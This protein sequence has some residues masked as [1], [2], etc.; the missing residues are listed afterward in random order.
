MG[1]FLD[2]RSQMARMNIRLFRVGLSCSFLVLASGITVA[3]EPAAKAP[4]VPIARAVVREVTDH[5]DFTG[6]TEAPI[7]VD[8]RARA[9]GYLIKAA[10]REGAEVKQGDVLFEIDPR[11]YQAEL[12]KVEA[13]VKLAEAHLKLA[14]AVQMRAAAQLAQKTIG[15]EEFDRVAGERILAEAQVGAA[16]ARRTLA[17]L[18][19]DYTRVLAPVGGRV[20]RRLVD[21]GNLVKADET[22]LA[23]L[24]SRSTV[25]IY[26]DVDERS[27]LRLLRLVRE[28]KAKTEKIPAAIGLADEEGFPHRGVVDLTDNQ[29]NPDTG[30]LRMR[31]VLANKDGLLMPGMFVRVRLTIGEPHKVVCIPEQAVMVEEGLRYVFVVGDKDAIERQAV[32]LGPQRNGQRVVTR[33]LKVDERIVVGRLQGL[34]PGMVVRPR[35]Q[36][37]PAPKQE[38]YPES[39]GASAAPSMWGQAGSGILVGTVYPGASAQVVSDAV[40]VP[41]EQQVN[42]LETIRSLR[43]RCTHDGKYSLAL[44]FARG[45]D[46]K[47]MQVLVQNRVNLALPVLPRVLQNTGV[48]VKQGTSGVLMIVNLSSPGDNHDDL[49]LGNY[50]NIQI[51]DELARLPGVGEVAL[52]GQ[53]D[54]GLRVCLDPDKL[55]ARSLNAGDVVRALKDQNIKVMAGEIGPPPV[56]RGRVF[57]YRLSTMGRLIN[58]EGFADIILRADG[59]GRIIRLKDVAHIELSTGGPQSQAFFNGRPVAALVIRSTGEAPLRKVQIALQDVLSQLRARLAKGLDLAVAFDFTANLEIPERPATPE[60]LLL[61]LHLPASASAERALQVLKHCQTL[62]RPLP[63]VQDVLAMSDNPFDLF[64][65]GPCILV[66]LTPAEKR[67]AGREEVARAIRAKLDEFKELTLRLRDLSGPGR[68]PRCGYPIDLAIRGPELERVREFAKKLVE[69]M[70]ESK[71]LTDVWANPDSE[72]RLQR[73]VEIDRTAAAARSVSLNDIF[74]TLQVYGGSL[75]VNDFTRFGR[76]WRVEV[77]AEPGSGDWAK[78]L[79]KLK[80][81]NSRGQMIPL[82]TLVK[83][84]EAEGPAALDFLDFWPMVEITAN[85]DSGVKLDVARKLCEVLAEEMRKELRLP[86]DYRLIWLP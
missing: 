13:E 55:A 51:K 7:R 19:L 39:G 33:G 8:L 12:D 32:V 56:P 67:K 26:F 85:P 81:R 58:P 64:G 35:E 61:D 80:I 41:I 68:F 42:G 9:T 4:E 29:V 49:F 2:P 34:R 83:V 36:D 50:A 25:Y 53:S 38:Q 23:T 66:R 82:N 16:K 70:G 63:G 30:T 47:M 62:L 74:N 3:G 69:R 73:I 11:P 76:T 6:R 5:E 44:T 27:A 1:L 17:Q 43:S 20:G 15:Q 46:L 79:R 14:D 52:L 77:Q 48:S 75:Y 37:A 18:N 24:V 65:D 28:D 78:N 84:G 21:P 54:F 45:V 40:R 86:V 59:E 10:F 60:Y 71:K 31:A 57:Q 22:I 72:P